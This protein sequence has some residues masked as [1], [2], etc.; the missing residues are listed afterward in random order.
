MLQPIMVLQ[1]P[2]SERVAGWRDR[3]LAFARFLA[4]RFLDDKCF[5]AAGALSYT[6]LFALVPLAAAV[7][8]ILAAFPQFETWSAEVTHFVF[9]NFVPSAAQEV[10]DYLTRFAG[11]AKTLTG[12]GIVALI[13]TAL[14]MMASV[15]ETFNR[16]FRAPARRRRLAR[17][18]VYWT[19]LTLG[20][21]LLAA[22][23]AATSYLLSLPLVGGADREYRLSERLLA[24]LPWVVTWTALTL[25]YLVIPNGSVRWRNA[26]I[27]GLVAMVLFELAKQGFAEYLARA[28]FRDVYG[29]LAVLPIFLFWIWLMW[30][31]VLLG[32][33]LA[34][35]LSA[36]RYRPL[37]LRV[38]RGLEFAYL[39]QV[40]A[41]I[42]HATRA[43][44]PCSRTELARLEPN[45]TDMQLDRFLDELRGLK[46]AQRNEFGQWAALRDLAEV[47]LSELFT[48][49]RYHWPDA[50][51][52]TRLRAQL[53]ARDAR[54]AAFLADG[55]AAQAALLARPVADVLTD[56]AAP[57]Q[58]P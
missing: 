23:L 30:V 45:L 7:F 13:A 54:L 44:S 26:A 49:G 42:V 43:G 35:T 16:I 40:L 9:A 17:F 50:G 31:V 18:V 12:A 56:S 34:S 48:H 41:H 55:V 14:V 2:S 57:Q 25:A 28:S 5:E 4:R 11:Q 37:A 6:T 46:L 15:E 1:W 53:D 21:I 29:S 24:L 47:P 58:Q 39:V 19:V 10:E 8:G 22:S 52:L 27:G 51:E 32:A 33:S 3:M 20:P 38:T 36:F